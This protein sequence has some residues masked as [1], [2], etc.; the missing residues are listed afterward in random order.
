MRKN[1]KG[2]KEKLGDRKSKKKRM[3]TGGEV[4]WGSLQQ[5]H[6]LDGVIG[7]TTRNTRVTWTEIG[8]SGRE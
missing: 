2:M 4:S 5:E 8:R 7:D 3:T 1:M 6:Y